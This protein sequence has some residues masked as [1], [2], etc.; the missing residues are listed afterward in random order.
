LQQL[1]SANPNLDTNLAN[2]IYK[3][4]LNEERTDYAVNDYYELSAKGINEMVSFGGEQY[5]LLKNGYVK[6]IDFMRDKM[7]ANSIKLNE[8]VMNIDSSNSSVVRVQT[9]NNSTKASITYE[10]RIVIV[11]VSLG[12]LKA[13]HTSL[14]KPKL[15]DK[16]INAI[17]RLG[18]GVV[19]KLF[20]VFDR[21][22]F[23][24]NEQGIQIVWQDN[25]NFALIT[26]N[27]V[28]NL[29]VS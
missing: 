16:K 15:S 6:L 25:L 5:T 22:V 18:F 23:E 27:E 29:N 10:S 9:Y 12:Y 28:C 1:K 26:A 13:K 7:P 17:D 8:I 3:T 24:N 21:N 14:F 20:I 2:A 11:T 4:K 19:D